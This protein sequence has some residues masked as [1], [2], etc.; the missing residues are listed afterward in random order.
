MQIDGHIHVVSEQHQKKHNMLCFCSNPFILYGMDYCKHTGCWALF[1]VKDDKR[2]NR[3]SSQIKSLKH[4]NIEHENRWWTQIKT[5][6]PCKFKTLK[7][8]N[9]KHVKFVKDKTLDEKLH[10]I[11]SHFSSKRRCNFSHSTRVFNFVLCKRR[12][13]VVFNICCMWE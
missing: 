12:Y 9:I 7:Y 8:W 13:I 6:Q 2:A 11:F 3:W 5:L 4:W 1:F 10:A